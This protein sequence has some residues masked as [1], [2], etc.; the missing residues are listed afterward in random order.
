MSWRL[1][2][3]PK[4]VK[5]KIPPWALALACIVLVIVVFFTLWKALIAP[6]TVFKPTEVSRVTLRAQCVVGDFSGV[7]GIPVVVY[8]IHYEQIGADTLAPPTF[9]KTIELSKP[10]RGAIIV[11]AEVPTG[12]Y[13]F[14][15]EH[16]VYD[17][18]LG[19]EVWLFPVTAEEM[20]VTLKFAKVGG[21]EILST[22]GN[23]T[24]PNASVTYVTP[25]V[26]FKFIHMIKN[27]TVLIRFE[28]NETKVRVVNASFMVADLSGRP[29]YFVNGSYFIGN[30]ISSTEREMTLLLP[31]RLYVEVGPLW[32]SS[33]DYIIMWIEFRGEGISPVSVPIYIFVS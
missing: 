5:K 31:M 17:V 13:I 3:A 16:V 18:S 28:Y 33:A 1:E 6:A 24:V 22:S 10:A 11:V 12:Y 25:T 8:N 20:D 7:S 32:N 4:E 29:V 9:T 15:D 14:E 26:K 23:F 21:I 2:V 27:V 19:R 30:L